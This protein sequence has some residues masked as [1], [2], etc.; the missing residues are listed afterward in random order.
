V[1][2][3]INVHAHCESVIAMLPSLLTWSLSLLYNEVLISMCIV[4]SVWILYV[5]Y[6]HEQITYGNYMNFA[7][8]YF[9]DSAELEVI[10]RLSTTAYEREFPKV[11][12]ACICLYSVTRSSYK[13]ILQYAS[14][15]V[16]K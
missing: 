16:Y 13:K 3:L 9:F 8:E 12:C 2:A 1:L 7:Y 4:R 15:C 11:S 10:N 14:S 6:V 5:Y